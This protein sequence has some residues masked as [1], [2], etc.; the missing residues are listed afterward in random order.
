M[1]LIAQSSFTF[2]WLVMLHFK[3]F[4]FP[5]SQQFLCLSHI[6]YATI[7]IKTGTH[8]DSIVSVYDPGKR[9][10]KFQLIKDPPNFTK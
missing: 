7:L 8:D 9:G 4:L 3:E 5:Q 6:K 10:K 2:Q 1:D